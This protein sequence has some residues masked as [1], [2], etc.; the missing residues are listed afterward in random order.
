M[1]NEKTKFVIE[2]LNKKKLVAFAGDGVNDTP[3]IVAADVGFAMGGIGSDVAVENAD[4]VLMED[5]P[6]KIY[7]SIKIA[8]KTKHVAI[9][10][11]IV[12]LLVKLGVIILILLG[13][14]GQ[15]GMII[16]VLADTGLSVL[17]ILN[18]LLLFYRKVD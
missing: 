14:L 10:N 2:S 13:L 15:F 6:R 18:S 11:I 7:T 3:S 16:A 17:M 9:F 4:V 12:S 8:K 1:P 5:N